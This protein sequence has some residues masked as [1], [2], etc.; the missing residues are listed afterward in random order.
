MQQLELEHP[1]FLGLLISKRIFR[2]VSSKRKSKRGRKRKTASLT[3]KFLVRNSTMQPY[4]TSK[5]LQRELL[6]TKVRVGSM[7][8]RRRLIEAGR[9]G[10]NLIKKQL[11]KPA[12]KKTRLNWGRKYQSWTA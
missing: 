9:Y 10:R 12:K 1:V 4:K 3:D 2:A 6:A 7:T 8:D 5:D 11:L